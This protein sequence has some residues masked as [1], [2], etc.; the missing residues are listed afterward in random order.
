MTQLEIEILH[1]PTCPHWRSVHR[2]IEELARDEGIAVVIAET[3]IAD[4]RDA[5][6]R[7]FPGS[8]TVL[9]EGRDIEPQAAGAPADYGLG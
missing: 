1:T 6:G 9:I 3:S 8:P 4:P 7:R 5:E 2:R